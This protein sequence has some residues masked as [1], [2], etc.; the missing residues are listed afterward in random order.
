MSSRMRAAAAL[1]TIIAGRHRS[2]LG[3]APQTKK[4]KT[5]LSANASSTYCG[6]PP[7]RRILCSHHACASDPLLDSREPLELV[8]GIFERAIVHLPA[9]RARSETCSDTR[10]LAAG[11]SSADG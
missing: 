10:H 6:K 9:G 5:A 3:F 11:R 1:Q 2:R 8:E 4:W 7:T